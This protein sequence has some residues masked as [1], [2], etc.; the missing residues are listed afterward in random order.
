MEQKPK[1]KIIYSD[2]VI[3]FLNGL[4]S[5]VRVKIMYNINKSKFV[6]DKNI[7]KKLDDTDGLWEFRTLYNGI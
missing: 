1:F 3:S 2:D 5:K 6:M 7:F 4:E